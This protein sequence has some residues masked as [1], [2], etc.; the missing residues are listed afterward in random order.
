MMAVVR[1]SIAP[2]YGEARTASERVDEVLY[3]WQVDVLS[4]CGE[5]CRISTDYGYQGYVLAGDLEL[6][7]L[8]LP[9]EQMQIGR[10]FVDVLSS[11]HVRGDVVATLPRGGFLTLAGEIGDY[12]PVKMVGGRICY[13]RG[14]TLEEQAQQVVDETKL[15]RGLAAAAEL[16]LNTQYRWGGKTHLGIDCSGLTFMAYRLNGITIWRDAHHKDGYPLRKIPPA[17]AE[18]GD[19]IYFQGHVAMV[20]EGGN[21]IH[22]SH[23]NN[24]VKVQKL[25]KYP[26]EILYACTIF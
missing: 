19:L 11:P 3:G 12:T 14:D 2:V 26:Q 18:V 21:I 16:Y 24:G 17:V 20:L 4:R 13:I 7:P 25:A 22:S 5:F 8:P 9:G 23:G 6:A 10:D 1:S 15:R